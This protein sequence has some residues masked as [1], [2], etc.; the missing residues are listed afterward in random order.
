M[1]QNYWH[2]RG[3]G[4]RRGNPKENGSNVIAFPGQTVRVQW[5]KGQNEYTVL[6]SG[7]T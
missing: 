5:N 2:S 1:K 6:G 7:K 3:T 4:Y